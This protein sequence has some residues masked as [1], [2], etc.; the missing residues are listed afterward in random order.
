MK[1]LL[2]VTALLI[3]KVGFS[4]INSDNNDSGFIISN[5]IKIND[6]KVYICGSY[7]GNVKIN[8]LSI[9]GKDF[10]QPFLIVKDINKDIFSLNRPITSLNGYAEFRNIIVNSDNVIITGV[11]TKTIL[12][13]SDTITAIGSWDAF[14]IKLNNNDSLLW[15]KIYSNLGNNFEPILSTYEGN[16][17]TLN[18][19]EVN[20]S[21]KLMFQSISLSNGTTNWIKDISSCVIQ[22][23]QCINV[24][25]DTIKVY[26]NT[27]QIIKV[28]NF[29]LDGFFLNTL[30][31]SNFI[32]YS[33]RKQFINNKDFWLNAQKVN[34]FSLN[35]QYYDK[36]DFI[37]QELKINSMYFVSCDLLNNNDSTI[38][39]EVTYQDYIEFDSTVY[40]E[41][42]TSNC[43]FFLYNMNTKEV[44]DLS[45]LPIKNI[46]RIA[47]DDSTIYVIS[48]YIDASNDFENSIL[49]RRKNNTDFKFLTIKKKL[50]EEVKLTNQTIHVVNQA[51]IF[52]N[53]N[54][55]LSFNLYYTNFKDIS[56][57]TLFNSI[58][59]LID[60]DYSVNNEGLISIVPNSIISNGIYVLQVQSKSSDVLKNFIFVVN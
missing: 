46:H 21:I 12:I 42:D 38:F 39:I 26:S 2:L 35:L 31:S 11:F 51:L 41:S 1:T 45:H 13:N 20:D 18:N 23:A 37:N 56:N 28:N 48:N 57:L 53:P 52:P 25:N 36:N 30:T 44:S 24:I 4:Q 47:C 16:L 8:K 5:D 10:N 14:I 9:E 43:I 49:E 59:N 7:I 33:I 17:Y 34:D 60:I 6:G 29:N 15:Y 55:G 19:V 54:D 40:Y 58:G 32:N 3:V 22:N 50:L 27:N